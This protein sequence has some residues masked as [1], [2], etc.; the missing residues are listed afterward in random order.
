MLLEQL[1]IPESI[2]ED[3]MS[4]YIE[5]DKFI[6]GWQH[7]KERTTTG[8]AFLHFSH[9]K[10][11]TRD[12]LIA[13]FEATMSHVPHATGY[14]PKCW[15]HVVDFELLKKRVYTD[16]KCFGRF[17]SMSRISIRTIDC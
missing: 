12:P 8:S 6:Q 15:Q 14:S 4:A 5:T 11:G 9:F 3:P 7:T 10:A 13:D 16:R 17:N 2:K 1:K